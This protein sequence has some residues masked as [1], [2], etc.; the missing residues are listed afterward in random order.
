[1]VAASSSGHPGPFSVP[2]GSSCC[3]VLVSE[4]QGDGSQSQSHLFREVFAGLSR[5]SMGS[6]LNLTS[7]R[8]AT[9]LGTSSTKGD[10]NHMRSHPGTGRGQSNP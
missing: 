8:T 5:S 2:C 1:M 4:A 9:Y 3:S 7:Q 6:V 10:T